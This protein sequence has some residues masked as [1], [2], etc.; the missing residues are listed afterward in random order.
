MFY[1]VH[2]C[3]NGPQIQNRDDGTLIIHPTYRVPGWHE[4][5]R[6][7]TPG[8]IRSRFGMRGTVGVT[9]PAGP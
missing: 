1:G 6:W 5:A 8:G 9:P 3:F 7:W 2:P 4:A